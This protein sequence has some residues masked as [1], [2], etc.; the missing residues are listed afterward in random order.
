MESVA[1]I[2]ASLVVFGVVILAAA[3]LFWVFRDALVE[4]AGIAF[5]L[6][7]VAVVLLF[8]SSSCVV[9]M[10]SHRYRNPDRPVY[11]WAFFISGGILGVE[12]LC[13]KL[14]QRRK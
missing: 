3:F 6:L 2:L 13:L 9:A 10:D 7:Q 4:I 5:W 8:L 1:Q 12:A 14:F 11:V